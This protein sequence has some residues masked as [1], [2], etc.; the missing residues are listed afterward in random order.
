[1]L[2]CQKWLQNLSYFILGLVLSTLLNFPAMGQSP[3]TLY[4]QALD[5]F[6]VG[7]MESAISL[8]Q[9]VIENKPEKSLKGRAYLMLAQAY[10]DLGFI[11]KASDIWEQAK[12][13]DVTSLTAFVDSIE[14]NLAL[15]Q[16]DFERAITAYEKAP[17][18]LGV[19]NNLSQVYEQQSQLKQQLAKE[20]HLEGN[21]QEEDIFK[22][23]ASKELKIAKD[24][25]QRAIQLASDEVSLDAAR[26]WIRWYQLGELKGLHQALNILQ[27]LPDSFDKGLQLIE[28]ARQN[29]I[30]LALAE[31]VAHT[32][33]HSFLLAEVERLYAKELEQNKHY[34]EAIQRILNAYGLVAQSNLEL[35]FQIQWDLGRLY[36]QINNS[37]ESRKYYRQAILSTE[38]VRKNLASA[39]RRIQLNFQDK[40]NVLYREFLSRLLNNPNQQDLREVIKTKQQFQLAELESY[41]GNPCQVSRTNKTINLTNQVTIHTII[42]PSSLH[43]ILE[44][45][46]GQYRH[47]AINISQADL[48]SLIRSWRLDLEDEFTFNFRTTSEQLYDWLIAPWTEELAG[49]KTLIFVNDGVLWSVP[50]S[51]LWKD[52]YLIESYQIAY[53]L[54]LEVSTQ[55]DSQELFPVLFGTTQSSQVF[56]TSLPFVKTELEN[57]SEIVG[58]EAYLDDLFNLKK[59]NQALKSQEYTI[60][61]I[62]SHGKF[63]SF[64]NSFIQTG[65]G[66]LSLEQ[67]EQFL[68]TRKAP[69]NLLTLS[70]CQTAVGN[71]RSIL[72]IAGVAIR[73]NIPSVLGT[74]WFVNDSTTSELMINFYRIWN[75]QS[76]P[77]ESLRQ[78]QLQL[79]Q[80]TSSP[81]PKIHPRF[82]APY[83]FLIS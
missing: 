19:L 59:F 35:L 21:Q 12:K 10:L 70:A 33:N 79:I 37:Q 30:G 83:L 3:A 27:Q 17:Q 76:S 5:L 64:E 2:I 26:S 81:Q 62:A 77:L 73:S 56:K 14:G 4:Q 61:H 24:I 60:L 34:K 55:E 13:L 65:T 28:I 29:Q 43:E 49:I 46:N 71:D 16:H 11:H 36:N 25:A 80:S 74:F 47:Q 44:L 53:S 7:R 68:Q 42:L 58:G 32:L 40:I 57:I 9:Q 66:L 41:F 22:V 63:S 67:L 6:Q 18:S 54:G 51:A 48:E 52:H 20:A 23:Q 45:P 8:W 75:N 82:W 38:Q 50:M 39:P 1:M 31:S 15:A 72:G 78:A 69:L